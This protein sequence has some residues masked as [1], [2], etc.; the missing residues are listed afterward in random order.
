MWGLRIEFSNKIGRWDGGDALMR[1]RTYRTWA[2]VAANSDRVHLSKG[3]PGCC[4]LGHYAT[5]ALWQSSNGG[6]MSGER[7][8]AGE[9][10]GGAHRGG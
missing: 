8:I 7:I 5:Y 9:S 3:G 4:Y 10:G 6:A 1:C 2:G